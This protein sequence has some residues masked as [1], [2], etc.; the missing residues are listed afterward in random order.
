MLGKISN[1][2]AGPCAGDMPNENTA[3]KMMTPAK[4]A[5]E[6]SSNAVVVALRTMCVRLLK[7]DP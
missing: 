2:N 7:Y 3:G 5:T 6:V 1:T 4:I